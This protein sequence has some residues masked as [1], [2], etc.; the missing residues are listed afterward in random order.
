[1]PSTNLC[2]IH[3]AKYLC[4]QDAQ[5]TLSKP[6]IH[7][8]R[9]QDGPPRPMEHGGG[10]QGRERVGNEEYAKNVLQKLPEMGTFESAACQIEHSHPRHTP[11]SHTHLCLVDSS[12]KSSS[13]AE[14][15][16]VPH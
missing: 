11:P 15:R 3:S 2:W 8:C 5:T 4:C 9:R 12:S 13:Y 7:P 10:A 14:P 16:A 1:M 6:Y